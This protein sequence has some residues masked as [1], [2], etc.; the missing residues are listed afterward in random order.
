LRGWPSGCSHPTTEDL[1]EA[2]RVGELSLKGF[3]RPITPFNVLR[4]KA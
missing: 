4:L 1:L 2:E 3:H